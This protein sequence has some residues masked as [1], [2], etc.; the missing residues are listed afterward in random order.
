MRHRRRSISVAA[1]RCCDL[2]S[3]LDPVFP[4]N[5]VGDKG[6]KGQPSS[7]RNEQ[8]ESGGFLLYL[9][10]VWTAHHFSTNS[11]D[12]P[13][14]LQT[15][16]FIFT[17]LLH[18]LAIILC[19]HSLPDGPEEFLYTLKHYVTPSLLAHRIPQAIVER[20]LAGR[21]LTAP[22]DRSLD[23]HRTSTRHNDNARE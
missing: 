7:C 5:P 8:I 3:A 21:L 16:S 18:S 10:A 9:A 20:P 1:P 23:L 2:L 13:S 17:I 22:P 4:C 6:P 15:L 11:T 12:N 19:C 14:N